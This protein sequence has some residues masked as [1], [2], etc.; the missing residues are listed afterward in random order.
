MIDLGSSWP[1][2]SKQYCLPPVG[3]STGPLAPWILWSL[4]VARKKF[5]FENKEI[6]EE[7]VITN[8]ITA[9]KE[10]L[11]EQTRDSSVKPPTNPQRAPIPSNTPVLKTDAAWKGDSLIAGL[12]WILEEEL[13]K[14]ERMVH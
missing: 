7:D 12:G 11:N 2:L 1:D 6:L 8:A 5:I 14:V 13:Q 3:I 10:W 4:W 9:A